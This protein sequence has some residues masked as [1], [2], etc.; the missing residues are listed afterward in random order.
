MADDFEVRWTLIGDA[1]RG[2][3]MEK[4]VPFDVMDEWTDEV[5]AIVR[6]HLAPP[7]QSGRSES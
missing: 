2:F 3:L 6:E 5:V 7:M 1:I 4:H